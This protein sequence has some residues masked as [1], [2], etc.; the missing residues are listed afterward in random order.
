MQQALPTCN[1]RC[2]HAT[3]VASTE[4]SCCSCCVCTAYRRRCEVSEAVSYSGYLE[5]QQSF[6][7]NIR[8]LA[9]NEKGLLVLQVLQASQG[10]L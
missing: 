5:V 7:S 3:G 10:L 8:R 9:W 1:R 4:S 2:L 6:A